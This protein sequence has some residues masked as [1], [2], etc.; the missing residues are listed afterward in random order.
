MSTPIVRSLLALLLVSPTLRASS[1]SGLVRIV[2]QPEGLPVFIDGRPVGTTPCA[3]VRWKTGPAVVQAVRGTAFQWSAVWTAETVLVRPNEVTD[4]R[5]KVSGPVLLTSDD[6]SVQVRDRAGYLY[7]LPMWWTTDRLE[8][9]S[10]LLHDSVA[11]P[12][13]STAGPGPWLMLSSIVQP[14]VPTVMK[15]PGALGVRSETWTIASGAAMIASGVLAV[16]FRDKAN[17]AAARYLDTRDPE[18]LADV[19][20]FDRLAG[21][22]MVAVQ[23][24]LGAFVLFLAGS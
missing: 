1:D 21:A 9:L 16:V 17:D 7:D 4:V 2:T 22:S 14:S 18:A 10:M 24:S 15:G 5:L 3:P 11:V 12:L 13:R 20:R 19:R 23:V 8:E 6:P